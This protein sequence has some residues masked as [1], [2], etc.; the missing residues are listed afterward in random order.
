MHVIR[1]EYRDGSI[2]DLHVKGG[3]VLQV[4]D[5]RIET[6]GEQFVQ[7]IVAAAATTDIIGV[8]WIEV[9]SEPVAPAQGLPTQEPDLA[10]AAADV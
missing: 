3:Q 5:E 9:R 6:V 10:A 2:A 4:F 1:L 7:G 8:E